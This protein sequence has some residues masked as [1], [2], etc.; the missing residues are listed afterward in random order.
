[1]LGDSL[2][3]QAAIIQEDEPKEIEEN[4]SEEIT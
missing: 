1:L 3:P 2:I 4:T